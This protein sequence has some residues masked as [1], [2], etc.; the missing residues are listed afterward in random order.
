MA[1]ATMNPNVVVA[2]VLLYLYASSCIVYQTLCAFALSALLPD[3]VIS[4]RSD[5]CVTLA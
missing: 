1:T 3:V 2:I 4:V 5:A